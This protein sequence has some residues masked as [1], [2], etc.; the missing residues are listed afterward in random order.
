MAIESNFRWNS[1]N[2]KEMIPKTKLLNSGRM[3]EI[4]VDESSR[5]L[6]LLASHGRLPFLASRGR[7][8]E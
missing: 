3:D 4:H 6:P 1:T 2:L 5:A 8:R 7:V